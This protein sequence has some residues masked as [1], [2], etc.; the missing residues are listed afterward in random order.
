MNEKLIIVNFSR[1]RKLETQFLATKIISV[2]GKFDTEALEIDKAYNLLVE[3]EPQIA[4]LE[5]NSRSHPNSEVLKVL[6]EARINTAQG[7]I[8]RIRSLDKGKRTGMEQAI[9]IAEPILVRYLSNFRKKNFREKRQF[10]IQLFELIE[11]DEDLRNSIVTLK[12]MEDIEALQKMNRDI[13]RLDSERTK[14]LA[15]RPKVNT[16][17]IIEEIKFV[18]NNLFNQIKVAQYNNPQLDYNKLIGEINLT[19]KA[20]R[21]LLRARRTKSIRKQEPQELPTA[22]IVPMEEAEEQ[23]ADNEELLA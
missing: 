14:D 11:S 21:T 7:I 6:Y 9:Y 4:L 22:D 10:L 20:A 12:L 23:S 1:M 19:M 5:V 3:L 13:D 8:D 17:E 15:K 2:V 16:A 18:I